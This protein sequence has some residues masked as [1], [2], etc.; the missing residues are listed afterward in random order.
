MPELSAHS[1]MGSPFSRVPRQHGSQ[2]APNGLSA[3][4]V[5]T[6]VSSVYLEPQAP[7]S[8]PTW[9][10]RSRGVVGLDAPAVPLRPLSGPRRPATGVIF[11]GTAEARAF[12][13]RREDTWIRYV[14]PH[15]LD[16]M[17]QRGISRE[18]V[19]AAIRRPDN[20]RR[21]RRERTQFEKTLSRNRRIAVVA[22]E[23]SDTIWVITAYWM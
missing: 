16:R 10:T 3:A 19:A 2:G 11:S 13:M 22:K 1:S 18:Q 20:A 23:T 6:A 17:Y 14:E 5:G 12:R 15:G 7:P 9:R 21:A 4:C 8:H